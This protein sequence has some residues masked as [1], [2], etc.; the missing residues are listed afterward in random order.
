MNENEF[1]QYVEL[2]NSGNYREVVNSYYHHN[3]RI[4]IYGVNFTRGA[5]DTLQWLQNNHDG[6]VETMLVD[7]LWI[8]ANRRDVYVRVRERL[9]ALETV[10]RLASGP[11]APGQVRTTSFRAHYLVRDGK[12][13]RITLDLPTDQS[14]RTDEPVSVPVAARDFRPREVVT[15]VIESDDYAFDDAQQ[16]IID[17]PQRSFRQ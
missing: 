3:I 15:P 5:S 17:S 1:A 14:S 2:Y 9:V 4:D 16:W 11:L 10:K 8:S 13:V 12:F 7:D 6:L